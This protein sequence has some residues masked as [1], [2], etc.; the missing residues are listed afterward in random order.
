M[1]HA[2]MTRHLRILIL[3]L[4]LLSACASAA[5]Q[6]GASTTAAPA[7]ASSPASPALSQAEFEAAYRAKA[8]SLRQ[9]YTAA[10]VRFMTNM[11]GHHAQALEMSRLAPTHGASGTIRTLA[12]RIINAQQ[13]EITVMQQW[14]RDRSQPVPA[15][16]PTS[17]MDH[18]AGHHQHMAGMLTPA[19]L[20]QLEAAKGQ[21]FDRLF[22]QF[23]IQHH[24][25]AVSMVTELFATDG[26]AQD[27]PV[28]KFA[29]DVQADQS[30]EVARM[31]RMLAAMPPANAGGQTP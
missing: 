17:A 14:L 8:D 26:A 19:Q 3:S 5:A 12:A 27:E 10:D 21:A 1:N 9:R 22:L 31:E 6:G 7:A 11:I 25:G 24:K 18:S 29:S 23:M 28:F 13:D 15:I 4:P 20:K 30:S 16:Q 2:G